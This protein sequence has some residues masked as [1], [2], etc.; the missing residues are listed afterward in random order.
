MLQLHAAVVARLVPVALGP[1]ALALMTAYAHAVCGG[2]MSVLHVSPNVIQ[3]RDLDGVPGHGLNALT[4][5]SREVDGISLVVLEGANRCP[6]EAS[7]VPI[8]Q[9]SDVTST[10]ISSTPSARLGATL[11]AGATTVPVSSQLWSHAVAV[12]PEPTLVTPH[13]ESPAGD[14]SLSSELLAAG[15]IPVDE[16]DSILDK[17]PD[18]R[19]LRPALAR[20]GAGLSR[21]YTGERIGEALLHGLILPYVLTAL[22]GD[23]QENAL[24]NAGPLGDAVVAGLR[25]LRARIC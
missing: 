8:L 7:V 23:E 3:P 13:I 2:R 25:R 12:Y 15:E 9:L 14:L 21:F 22:S 6:L 24:N 20:F 18:C 1:S 10:R 16:V 4:E 5:A 11:V 17:W 19:D